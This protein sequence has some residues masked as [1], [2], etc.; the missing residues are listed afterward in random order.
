MIPWS[1]GSS[2]IAIIFYIVISLCVIHLVFIYLGYRS[3]FSKSEFNSLEFTHKGQLNED[4]LAQSKIAHEVKYKSMNSKLFKQDEEPPK[5]QYVSQIKKSFEVDYP[6][7]S[8]IGT[9]NST[10]QRRQSN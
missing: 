4:A 1:S 8:G 5:Q 6:E 9:E 3:N 2:T 10:S 7:L